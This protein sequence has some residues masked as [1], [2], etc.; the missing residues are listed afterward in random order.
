[1]VQNSAAQMLKLRKPVFQGDFQGVSRWGCQASTPLVSSLPISALSIN[2]WQ[3]GTETQ[4]SS[5]FL[6]ICLHRFSGTFTI[7]FRLLLLTAGALGGLR[8]ELHRQ[9]SRGPSP[10][11]SAAVGLLK[12]PATAKGEPLIQFFQVTPQS[13]TTHY[14]CA[15]AE[16]ARWKL[17]IQGKIFFGKVFEYLKCCSATNFWTLFIDV[18]DNGFHAFHKILPHEN[19][20]I[21]KLF[22]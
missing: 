2:I 12:F 15:S 19:I 8:A 14:L 4:Q 18:T 16:A 5:T 22:F 7:D 11:R 3:A 1:M 17:F 21:C 10:I 13:Y 20:I 9:L 6:R